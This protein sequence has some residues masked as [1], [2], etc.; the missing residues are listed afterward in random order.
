M[1]ALLKVSAVLVPT[2]FLSAAAVAQTGE[3]AAAVRGE[4]VHRG[5]MLQ[6]AAEIKAVSY[7][8]AGSHKAS[9]QLGSLD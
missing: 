3:F 9:Q 4:V 5:Y 7:G 8:V 2:L 1:R 6:D